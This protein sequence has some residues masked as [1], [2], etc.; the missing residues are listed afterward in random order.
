MTVPENPRPGRSTR[1]SNET[2]LCN[3]LKRRNLGGSG[4][5]PTG[6]VG[7]W[8][9]TAVTNDLPIDIAE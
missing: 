9:E 2:P 1:R 5:A 3:G 6:D 8:I 7:G 4:A